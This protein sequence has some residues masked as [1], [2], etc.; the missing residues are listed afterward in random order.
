MEKISRTKWQE[1]EN[2]FLNGELND[3]AFC[4]SKNLELEWFR[5]ELAKSEAREN[6]GGKKEAGDRLFVELLPQFESPG[7]SE[8]GSL[9][10]KYREVDIELGA[11]FSAEIFRQALRVIREEL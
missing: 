10:V 5:K 1:L 4:R 3:E 8:A 9:K 6:T 2:E 11:G 7:A